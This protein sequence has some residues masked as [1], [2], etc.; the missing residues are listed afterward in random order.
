MRLAKF[1]ILLTLCSVLPFS[2]MGERYMGVLRAQE[3]TE[4]VPDFEFNHQTYDFGQVVEKVSHTFTFTNTGDAPLVLKHV[5]T[6]CG[7][8]TT[9]YTTTPIEPGKTGKVVVSF[10]PTTQRAG[11]FRR[12][13][14][15]YTNSPKNYTRLFI[16]GEV[17][18]T[19]E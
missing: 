13:V 4:K 1:F 7:C 19:E 9:E 2:P 8:T 16:K 15:V 18:K 11:T 14:T 12:S 3:Q 5:A 6:G 10:N 17:V